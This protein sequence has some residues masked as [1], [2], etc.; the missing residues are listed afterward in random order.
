MNRGRGGRPPLNLE[1]GAILRA[2]RDRGTVKG[3]ARELRCSDAYIHA[4]L[5]RAG[6]TLTEVLEADGIDGLLTKKVQIVK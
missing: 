5:R 3:A 4:R 6:L 2:I 1:L